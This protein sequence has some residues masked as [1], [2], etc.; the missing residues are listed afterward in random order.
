VPAKER[1]KMFG[2]VTVF[3]C[4]CFPSYPHKDFIFWLLGNS[5]FVKYGSCRIRRGRFVSHFLPLNA[6]KKQVGNFGKNSVEGMA[7]AIFLIDILHLR[8]Y[9]EALNLSR[10]SFLGKCELN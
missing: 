7:G 6:L 2:M 3:R 4:L 9:K 8:G 5:F 1:A 10:A